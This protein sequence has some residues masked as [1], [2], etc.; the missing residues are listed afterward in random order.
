VVLEL[1]VIE[2]SFFFALAPEAVERFADALVA[3]L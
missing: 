1:E 2:P 3:R